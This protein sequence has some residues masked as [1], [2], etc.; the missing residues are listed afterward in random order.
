MRIDWDSLVDTGDLLVSRRWTGYSATL[1]LLGGTFA[2]HVAMIV[3]EGGHIY[4]IESQPDYW[5]YSQ[6]RGVQLTDLSTWLQNAEQADSEVV[7]LPL[8]P[9]LRD[10]SF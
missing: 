10:S 6:M 4:V 3:K 8:R 9:E 7:W 1:M 5:G 2:S